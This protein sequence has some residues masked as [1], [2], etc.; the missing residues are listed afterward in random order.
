MFHVVLTYT[1]VIYLDIIYQLK[2]SFSHCH[3]TKS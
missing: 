3:Q 1:Y 2:W